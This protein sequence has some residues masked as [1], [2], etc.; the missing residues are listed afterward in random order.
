MKQ[1]TEQRLI[2]V[3]EES[4][5]GSGD[6]LEGVTAAS[7]FASDLEMDSLDM[8]E[9]IMSAE[10]EFDIDI[11][12]DEV[13]KLNTVGDAVALI[14]RL[15]AA[16]VKG[17]NGWIG[18]GREGTL[19]E[20]GEWKGPAHIGDPVPAMAERV[21]RWLTEG[22]EVRIFTA[23]VFHD[24]TDGRRADAITARRAILAWLEKNGFPTMEITCVK[25]YAMLELWD[26]RAVQVIPNTGEPVGQSTRGLA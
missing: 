21:K 15:L 8:V 22:R 1:T 16:K 18:V 14:D 6:A 13:E 11:P 2:E 4:L 9:V 19:A 5:Y 20:Y 7:T 3:I 10:E 26:D 17:M 25:D 24:G 23:R 12:D